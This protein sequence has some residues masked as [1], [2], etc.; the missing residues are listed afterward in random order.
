MKVKSCPTLCDPMDCTLPGSSVHGIFQA[1]VLEWIAI[2]YSR[3]P[4]QPRVQTH[5]SCISQIGRQILYHCITWETLVMYA[6]PNANAEAFYGKKIACNLGICLNFPLNIYLMKQNL[7]D[8]FI[9]FM[10]LRVTCPEHPVDNSW[11]RITL[12]NKSNLLKV[13]IWTETKGRANSHWGHKI[14]E[15]PPQGHAQCRAG[16]WELASLLLGPC[17]NDLAWVIDSIRQIFSV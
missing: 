12:I 17:E 7:Q 4:S 2:S 15:V 3:D 5:I 10:T 11:I 13:K 16:S 1:R 8:W 14:V 9:H 6:H